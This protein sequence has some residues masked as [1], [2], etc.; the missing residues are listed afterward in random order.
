MRPP[1]PEITPPIEILPVFALI[2]R[3]AAKAKSVLSVWVFVELLVDLSFALGGGVWG[4]SFLVSLRE[5]FHDGL[6]SDSCLRF[7]DSCF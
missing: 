1:N 4:D 2:V 3:V 7:F 6:T 5:F